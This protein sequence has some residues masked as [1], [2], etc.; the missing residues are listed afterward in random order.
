[1]KITAT[2]AAAAIFATAQATQKLTMK[3][4]NS[5]AEGTTIFKDQ[6]DSVE[7][8][9]DMTIFDTDSDLYE[10]CR[11]GDYINMNWHIHVGK[12]F[13]G[14]GVGAECG[15]TAGSPPVGGHYDPTFACGPATDEVEACDATD[16]SVAEDAFVYPCNPEEYEK[17]PYACEVGDY[18]GKFGALRF[19]IDRHDKSIATI[20]ESDIDVYGPQLKLIE[21]RAIT[22][23]CGAP[24]IFC[25]TLSNGAYKP[26]SDYEEPEVDG[27][28]KKSSYAHKNSGH[29]GRKQRKHNN[30]KPKHSQR[31]HY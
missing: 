2:I 17:N 8:T 15:A 24:R 16:R 7:W 10:A 18:S 27:Y 26:T 3:V 4:D 19:K 23:H 22:F 25:G 5:A 12:P 31:K 29:K 13:G 1:M 30:R 20:E 6:G 28:N 14:Q 11:D 9:V 21:D